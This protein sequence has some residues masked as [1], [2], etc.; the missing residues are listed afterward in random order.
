MNRERIHRKNKMKIAVWFVLA[1]STIALIMLMEVK[2]YPLSVPK[3]ILAIE[4]GNASLVPLTSDA[5]KMVG[6]RGP[7]EKQLSAY[8]GQR[9][10]EYS[11]TNG[12][13]IFYKKDDVTLKVHS[14]FRKGYWWYDLDKAP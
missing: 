8:L 3:A 14:Y 7:S 9:G 10:W 4:T 13:L 11:D 2:E 1:L 5:S 12:D 6:R